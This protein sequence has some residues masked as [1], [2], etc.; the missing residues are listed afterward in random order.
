MI[1][2][3]A[4]GT[5]LLQSPIPVVTRYYGLCILSTLDVYKTTC[6]IDVSSYP[7][8]T[9]ECV[10][11]LAS[12]YGFPVMLHPFVNE[13]SDEIAN[14][15]TENG[16]WNITGMSVNITELNYGV[17]AV[18]MYLTLKRRYAFY[19]I[20][21]IFPMGLL[22]VL[23]SMV[24][25]LPAS[26]GEKMGFIMTVF[27]AHAVF[28]NIIQNSLPT[29]SDHISKLSLYLVLNEIQGFLAIAGA[30]IVENRYHSAPKVKEHDFSSCIQKWGKP[31]LQGQEL[32]ESAQTPTPDENRHG[33]SG[34]G[35]TGLLKQKCGNISDRHLDAVFFI[36]SFIM[37]F[38][39]IFVL[40]S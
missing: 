35:I 24:F 39:N 26:S 12:A 4:D 30:I 7:F 5:K 22:T 15:Q 38:G 16:E 6:K 34:N 2:N 17:F 37:A 3:A 14:L 20:N 19:V 18:K 28:L 13:L 27:M 32:N 11:V 1:Q 23:N 8:D 21:I 29:T 40:I 10:I 25:L 31:V 36:I 9:Q 33:A